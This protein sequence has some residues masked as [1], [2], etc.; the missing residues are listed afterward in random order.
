[1]PLLKICSTLYNVVYSFSE[2]SSSNKVQQKVSNN[3]VLLG[4]CVWVSSPLVLSSYYS[5]GKEGP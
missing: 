2:R 4:F 3:S 1:M 5:S